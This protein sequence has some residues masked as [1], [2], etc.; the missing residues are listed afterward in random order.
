MKIPKSQ[1]YVKND[2]IHKLIKHLVNDYACNEDKDE[3]IT[4]ILLRDEVLLTPPE[5]NTVKDIIENVVMEIN[6]E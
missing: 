2:I 3:I 1:E 5:I 4:E 6:H